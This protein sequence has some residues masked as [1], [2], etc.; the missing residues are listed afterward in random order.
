MA[1]CIDGLNI[2]GL[3]GECIYKLRE[4]FLLANEMVHF[5]HIRYVG[6][7][8]RLTKECPDNL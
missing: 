2:L 3:Q 8:M 4:G 6:V 1:A 5:Y 7:V